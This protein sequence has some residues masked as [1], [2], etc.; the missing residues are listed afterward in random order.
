MEHVRWLSQPTLR[1]PVVVAAFTFLAA[2][3]ILIYEAWKTN[4]GGIR[5]FT[6]EVWTA[7]KQYIDE[8]VNG[9]FPGPDH[10]Y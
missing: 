10:C 4:F 2:H 6:N 1:N 5:D 3:V 9:Q 7:I 8:V